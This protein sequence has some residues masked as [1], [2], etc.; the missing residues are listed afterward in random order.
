MAPSGLVVGE[1]ADDAGVCVPGARCS[2]LAGRPGAAA[3]AEQLGLQASYPGCDVD[4]PRMYTVLPDGVSIAWIEGFEEASI[5][6]ATPRRAGP[7][8]DRVAVLAPGFRARRRCD[9]VVPAG[10][11][12]PVRPGDARRRD[13]SVDR[14]GGHDR[15]RRP[16]PA[17]RVPP[18]PLRGHRARLRRRRRSERRRAAHR[19]R[20]PGPPPRAPRIRRPAR[21][22]RTRGGPVGRRFGAVR[23]GCRTAASRSCSRRPTRSG[24]STPRTSRSSQGRPVLLYVAEGAPGEPVMVG[25]MDLADRRDAGH[26]LRCPGSFDERFRLHLGANGL[27]V[28]NTG[29]GLFVTSLPNTSAA[30]L[31]VHIDEQTMGS[32]PSVYTV[33]P[34]GTWVA[35][36]EAD[37]LVEMDV[38]PDGLGRAAA[39][40]PAVRHHRRGR[41]RR[42]G[43]RR[44]RHL[45]L[46]PGRPLRPPRRF[47][48][49]AGGSGRHA[50][51]RPS[52]H[53]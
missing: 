43:R 17:R 52:R 23:C 18:P 28:G 39:L 12:E 44:D 16:R 27:V 45:R 34:D 50:G 35:R 37:G 49:G 48:R 51:S 47:V 20:R 9:G 38:S 30:T 33:S 4:C 8:A 5:V 46:G 13:G 53:R 14:V 11:I 19:D 41:R 1:V 29:S 42:V 22:R 6:E 10:P 21:R 26:C 40:G 24:R 3:E 32:D 15:H 25:G 7:R 2:R 36:L 31:V